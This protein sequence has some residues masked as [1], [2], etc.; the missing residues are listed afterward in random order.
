ML[1]S[2]EDDDV[3]DCEVGTNVV[4]PWCSKTA[5]KSPTAGDS[6]VLTKVITADR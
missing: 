5:G 3:R 1:G 6:T 4:R 2:V